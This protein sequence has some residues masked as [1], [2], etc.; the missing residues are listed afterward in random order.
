MILLINGPHGVGKTSVANCIKKKTDK[1]CI[2]M[3]SDFYYKKMINEGRDFKARVDDEETRELLGRH[4]D[5]ISH[6]LPKLVKYSDEDLSSEE[7]V[8]AKELNKLI[9]RVANCEGYSISHID[10][11]GLINAK[12][13]ASEI[14]EVFELDSS[15]TTKLANV[16]G[17]ENSVTIY[18]KLYKTPDYGELW[19]ETKPSED[20]DNE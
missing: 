18:P 15:W 5:P 16:E 10:T 2:I 11:N 8:V 7:P 4:T 19:E 20:E 1:S 3:D 12:Y 9:L 14:R 6:I 17:Y 13:L